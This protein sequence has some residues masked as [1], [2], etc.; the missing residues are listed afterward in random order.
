MNKSNEITV[1][2]ELIK[3]GFHRLWQTILVENGALV[4]HVATSDVV[5][6]VVDTDD[7]EGVVG[8]IIKVLVGAVNLASE[9]I[10]VEGP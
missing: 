6:C 9:R 10:F 1:S 7:S 8:V 4:N 2:R 3:R 5:D